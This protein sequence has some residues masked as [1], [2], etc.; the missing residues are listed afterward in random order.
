MSMHNLK[1]ISL[2]LLLS[3]YVSLNNYI[4]LQNFNIS[5]RNLSLIKII[6]LTEQGELKWHFEFVFFYTQSVEN[7]FHNYTPTIC[8]LFLTKS[9]KLI[10]FIFT[11]TLKWMWLQF[12]FKKAL[13][14]RHLRC[15]PS[16]HSLT[17]LFLMILSENWF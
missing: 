17:T 6:I 11:S 14:A 9:D 10:L 16:L 1:Y 13:F 8:Q 5:S 15:H 3:F 12:S 2:S 4:L 7:L